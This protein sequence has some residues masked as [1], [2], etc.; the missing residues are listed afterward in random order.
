MESL[1]L[2]IYRRTLENIALLFNKKALSDDQV[3]NISVTLN[4]GGDTKL[5]KYIT[6]DQVGNTLDEG[7]IAPNDTTVVLINHE[8]NGIDPYADCEL[9]ISFGTND[10]KKLHRIFVYA[11]GVL[12]PTEKDDRKSNRHQYCWSTE[13]RKWV[14]MP[15]IKC[16]DGSYAIP[17]KVVK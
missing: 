11:F 7:I 9:L 13:E 12:P 6:S 10:K 1:N 5:L 14:K 16:E 2:R 8:Q 17:V 15:V 4:D 3:K